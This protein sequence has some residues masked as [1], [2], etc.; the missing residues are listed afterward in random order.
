MEKERNRD[1]FNALGADVCEQLD[2]LLDELSTREKLAIFL[3]ATSYLITCYPDPKAAFGHFVTTLLESI[4]INEANSDK[5]RNEGE[6][7]AYRFSW[8]L[9]L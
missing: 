6:G 1:E 8:S 3:S 7:G 5:P 4:V 9:P 2:S